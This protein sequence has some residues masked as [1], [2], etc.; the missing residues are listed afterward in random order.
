VTM[1]VKDQ[2]RVLA[3]ADVF[4]VIKTT[5]TDDWPYCLDFITEQGKLTSPAERRGHGTV[6]RHLEAMMGVGKR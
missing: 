1:C 6:Q 5:K 4:D 2:R 3:N